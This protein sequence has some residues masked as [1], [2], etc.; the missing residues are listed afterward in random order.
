MFYFNR[1]NLKVNF[2]FGNPQ[3]IGGLHGQCGM[4]GVF[5][6][7]FSLVPHCPFQKPMVDLLSLIVRLQKYIDCIEI[8]VKT[9]NANCSVRT[10]TAKKVCKKHKVVYGT[11]KY[12]ICT[13]SKYMYQFVYKINLE[14]VLTTIGYDRRPLP[15]QGGSHYIVTLYHLVKYLHL[16][17]LHTIS[18]MQDIMKFEVHLKYMYLTTTQKLGLGMYVQKYGPERYMIEI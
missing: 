9:R 18:I 10:L 17:Y 16:I 11:I 5:N 3:L 2:T 14:Q 1:S 4:L 8:Y 6:L 15:I 7:P 12:N 13:K